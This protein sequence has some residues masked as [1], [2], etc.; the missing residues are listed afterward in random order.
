MHAARAR[1]SLFVA[2]LTSSRKRW[3]SQCQPDH[4]PALLV[5]PGTQL[6]RQSLLRGQPFSQS[7]RPMCGALWF[8]QAARL[9]EAHAPPIRLLSVGMLVLDIQADT[10]ST[11]VEGFLGYNALLKAAG[12]GGNPFPFPLAVVVCGE[13]APGCPFQGRDPLTWALF[14]NAHRRR[15]VQACLLG[16]EDYL[17]S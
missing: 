4:N 7:L 2:L 17:K 16:K 10:G 12:V 15:A 5:R 11:S 14:G 6:K 9:A 13:V 1:V 8:H 3:P